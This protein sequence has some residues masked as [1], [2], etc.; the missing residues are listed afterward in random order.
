[1]SKKVSLEEKCSIPYCEL[2]VPDGIEIG[3]PCKVF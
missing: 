1:M 2:I 3:V